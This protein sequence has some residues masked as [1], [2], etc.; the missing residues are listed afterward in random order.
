MTEKTKIVHPFSLTKKT[1]FKRNRSGRKGMG[2]SKSGRMES[3]FLMMAAC[4][5]MA[6]VRGSTSLSSK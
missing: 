3:D 4:S 6:S 5:V 2:N 1:A